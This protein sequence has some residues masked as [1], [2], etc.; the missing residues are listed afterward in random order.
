M[1]SLSGRWVIY[2]HLRLKVKPPVG[3]TRVA[4]S[5]DYIDVQ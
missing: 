5:C 4:M 2:V 3:K 1:L